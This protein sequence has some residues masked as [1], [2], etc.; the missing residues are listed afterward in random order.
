MNQE[1]LVIGLTGGIAAGKSSV[2]RILG[3]LGCVVSDADAA[4][5]TA[6]DMPAVRDTLVTWWGDG[7]L[8]AEDCVDRAAVA[9]R[10]FSSESDRRRLEGLIHPLVHQRMG[11]CF[12]AAPEGAIAMVIDAPLLL[13]AGLGDDGAVIIYG[14]A[15]RQDRLARAIG[16]RGW[17]EEEFGRREAAQA[18]L[19]EKQSRADHVVVND[20]DEASLVAKVTAVL[21]AIRDSIASNPDHY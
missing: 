7:I 2:A 9:E 14:D 13:E 8:D 18:S 10:V 20:G 3:D 1:P 6:L 12:A 21:E 11:A 19:D 4:A 5:Q 17:S 15:P 16:R